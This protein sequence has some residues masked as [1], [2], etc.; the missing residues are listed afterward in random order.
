MKL[1]TSPTDPNITYQIKVLGFGN[2]AAGGYI[3]KQPEQDTSVNSARP[4]IT[5]DKSEVTITPGKSETITATIKTPV[6]AVGGLYALINIHPKMS[7]TSNGT[8]VV[9][10]MNVPIMITI[11]NTEL[12]KIGNVDIDTS[13]F[14]VVNTFFTNTGNTHY[15]GIKNIIGINNATSKAEYISTSPLITAIVPRET[16]KLSQ[17]I[18]KSLDAGIYTITSYIIAEDGSVIAINE[19]TVTKPLVTPITNISTSST[20]SSLGIEI[21]IISIIGAIFI[22]KKR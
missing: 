22:G 12:L 13:N 9:T 5:L 16:V 2:N 8:S 14:P 17:H 11:T 15:Y 21:L 6:S 20:Q 3:E 19:T 4:Y 18:N 10:A 7:Q 1:S